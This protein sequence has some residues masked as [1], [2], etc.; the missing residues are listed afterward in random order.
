MDG[1]RKGKVVRATERYEERLAK[2]NSKSFDFF[3][4]DLEKLRW[5]SQ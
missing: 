5:V 1:W 2:K 3:V 4:I